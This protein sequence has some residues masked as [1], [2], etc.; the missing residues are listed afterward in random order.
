MDAKGDPRKDLGIMCIKGHELIVKLTSQLQFGFSPIAGSE[1]RRPKQFGNSPGGSSFV[2]NIAQTTARPFT[3][4]P[5]PP[6]RPVQEEVVSVISPGFSSATL[7]NGPNSVP[8]RPFGSGRPS[9]FRPGPA[10]PPAP[11]PAGPPGGFGNGN[12]FRPGPPARPAG[13]PPARPAASRPSTIFG[14][15]PSANRPSGPPPPP[16]PF[17][18]LRGGRQNGGFNNGGDQKS[19][20]TST[21]VCIF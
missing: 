9:P 13:P 12:R 19:L 7:S 18:D 16:R 3:A 20:L 21:F 10:R 6:P 2:S 5:P 4:R 15:R 1:P 8:G 11:R 14:P 17:Q